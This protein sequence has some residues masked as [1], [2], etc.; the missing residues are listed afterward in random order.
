[1]PITLSELNRSIQSVIEGTFSNKT[2]DLIAEIG[3][4]NIKKESKV[5]YLDLVEKGTKSGE[6]IA[7]SAAQ[8]WGKEFETI[9]EFERVTGVPFQSGIKVLLKI[10]VH[11][12]SVYGLKINVLNVDPNYTLGALAQAKENTILLLLEKYPDK[13]II[14]GNICTSEGVLD[15][16]MNGKVD[17]IKVGIGNSGLLASSWIAYV[18]LPTG[19]HRYRGCFPFNRRKW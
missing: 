19:W 2:F 13:I 11:F 15:L 18:I 9:Q 6:F 14:A 12:H 5:A 16:A 4:V 17:I 8:I 3:Q 1:M 7:R 10:N